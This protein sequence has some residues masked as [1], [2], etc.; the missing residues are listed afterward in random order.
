LKIIFSLA[1]LILLVFTIFIYK[2]SSDN[3]NAL[4]NI[5]SQR[6]D[7][8]GKLNSSEE[9]INQLQNEDQFL[10][11][12]TLEEEIANIQNTYKKAV[13][14]YENLLDLKDK[15]K[16][17]SKFD[18]VFADSLTL[19]SQRNYAS[20]E[21]KLA[22]L[23]SDI[24]TESDK[25]AASFKVPDNLPVESAPPSSGYRRQKVQ[26]DSGLLMID[27]ISG[28]LGG[29]KVIVDTAS[30]SDCGNDCPVLSLAD[31]VSRNGAYAGVNGSYFCPATYPTC[32]GKTNSFDLL[33]MNKNKTYFNSSNNVYS[34][35]PAVIFGDNYIRFVSA[36]KE[37]GRDTSPN[38][39]LS[40][41]PLLLMGNEIRYQGDSDP[42]HQNKGG[43]S[44][45]ANK[46]NTVFI[47]VVHNA[48]V[49]E[50]AKVM[51]A[52]GMENAMNLDDG[53]ST[54][55]WFGGYKSGPGRNIPNAI[56]FVKK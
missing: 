49:M 42:K 55:L 17:T 46:G 12:K 14:V 6:N 40:N 4:K 33:V 36:T 23:T 9:N 30:N 35:N 41:F 34:E 26:I 28:D 2:K 19:L 45:V 8:Q 39:V 52:L 22:S 18:S 21:V 43:R 32:A 16:D 31:Y 3:Q 47:G 15:S 48:T 11:N 10:K 54:A 27:I 7:L 24:K 20:A 5:E 25:I 13:S 29:T 1:F 56:L 44:F 51:K 38:G 37:W 53:G 50:S